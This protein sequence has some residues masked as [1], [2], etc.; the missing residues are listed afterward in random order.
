[1]KVQCGVCRCFLIFQNFECV[2]KFGVFRFLTPGPNTKYQITLQTKKRK[3]EKALG[4]KK[5]EKEK[6]QGIDNKISRD[7]LFLQ[8]A[9]PI[10]FRIIDHTTCNV[11]IGIHIYLMTL[12]SKESLHT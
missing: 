11:E 4:K 8:S 10:Y 7:R 3:S 1:V 5:K 2:F 6:R 12:P 9:I